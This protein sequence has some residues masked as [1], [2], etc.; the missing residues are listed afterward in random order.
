MTRVVVELYGSLGHT[1]K[2][3]GSDVAIIL[4][5]EGEVPDEADVDAVPSRLSRI[6]QAG[7]LRL[8]GR[9]RR[10]RVADQIVFHRRKSL[11]LHP[12]GMRF[13][14]TDGAER[15]CSRASTIRWAAGSSSTRAI[16]SLRGAEAKA[17]PTRSSRRGA[18]PP[19]QGERSLAQHARPRERKGAPLRGRRRAGV[20]GLWKPC[21]RASAEA[22]SAKGML[23]GGLKVNGAPPPCTANCAP[24]H[25]PRPADAS[26]TGSTSARSRSTRRTRRAGAS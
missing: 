7:E 5:L 17:S 16:P 11:P 6:A 25:P 15:R 20:L 14:A 18:P 1:G 8:L 19:L 24:T 12:N 23:P 3:H 9:R 21:V 26:W 10:L 13:L 2:G 4:G 22:A